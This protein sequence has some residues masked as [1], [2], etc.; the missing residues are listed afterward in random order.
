MLDLE[1]RTALIGDLLEGAVPL[2]LEQ[3]RALRASHALAG[4]VA[5]DMAV[6][7]GDVLGG[8]Q[9]LVGQLLDAQGGVVAELRD[10][11]SDTF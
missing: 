9:A 5:D 1:K 10:S 7:D 8:G 6:G 3:D 11:A 2:V 4:W